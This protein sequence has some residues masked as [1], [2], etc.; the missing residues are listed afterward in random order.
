[1]P[2]M[3]IILLRFGI[4]TPTEVAVLSTLYAGAVSLLIYH[5]LT[6]KRLHAAVMEAGLASGVV[7]LVIMASAAIGW[8]LTFDQ[9][10]QGVAP[11]G[12]STW[13]PS[14]CWR[15]SRT[16]RPASC[17]DRHHFVQR[18]HDVPFRTGAGHAGPT[19]LPHPPLRPAHGRGP[20]PR[21]HRPGPGLGRRARHG[22]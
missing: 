18:K 14:P 11:W 21:L 16:S 2:V 22:V 17:A 15:S 12:R 8:L 7:L 20:G 6:L 4:A 5:D 1:L 3:I 13:S 19:R 10:P 9:M